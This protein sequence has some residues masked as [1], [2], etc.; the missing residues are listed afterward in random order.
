MKTLTN[1]LMIA[2]VAMAAVAGE[3]KAQSM[4]AEVPFSF[5]VS[6]KTMAAGSYLV[7]TR[8]NS[9]IPMFR[10]LNTDSKAPV[11]AVAAETRYESGPAKLVFRCGE[12]GCVLAQIWSGTAGAYNL[13]LPKA[14][15]S[16]RA[17]I[18]IKAETTKSAE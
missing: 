16:D 8:A 11:I 6:G 2:A 13:S 4:K 5:Q 9:G 7:S 3:A 14:G 17:M 12:G 18:E 1:S 10:L 15:P